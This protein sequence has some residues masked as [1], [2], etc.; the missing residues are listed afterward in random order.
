MERGRILILG[1]TKENTYEIRNLLDNK[2][3]ELE[4][5]LNGDV[6]KRVLS[7]RLM[8]LL[9]VHSE[10]L[11]EN[12]QEFFDFLENRGLHMPVLVF[13]EEAESYREK[14]AQSSA[15]S[16]LACFEK[17]YPVERVISY[18]RDL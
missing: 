10:A 17:P 11:G 3:F 16:T 5:A 12:S 15:V 8:Q 18:I 1:Q 9:V 4:I 13:G 14:I 2:R 6:G 7:S